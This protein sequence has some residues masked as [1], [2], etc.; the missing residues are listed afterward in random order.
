MK[1]HFITLFKF[2]A[3]L[4]MPLTASFAQDGLYGAQAPENAAYIRLINLS[5]NAKSIELT[6]KDKPLQA[7]AYNSSVYTFIDP[8]EL[9]LELSNG[10]TLKHDFKPN[11]AYTIVSNDEKVFVTST[12]FESN[13]KKASVYL[14]NLLSQPLSLKTVDGKHAVIKAI[15]SNQVGMREVNGIKIAFALFDDQGTNLAASEEIIFEPA[16]SYSY[17]AYT[18]ADDKTQLIAKSDN[19]DSLIE[20][21]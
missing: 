5:S 6:G 2:F 19:V 11:E 9:T 17:I 4:L 18:G 14:Y 15:K 3:L 1:K 7:S 10:Q 8:N 20:D 13:A 21:K 16:R 12:P